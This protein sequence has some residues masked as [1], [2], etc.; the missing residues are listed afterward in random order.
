[1][2]AIY[3][4]IDGKQVGPYTQDQLRQAIN[5]GQVTR[6][7]PAWHEGLTEWIHV[8]GLINEQ[9]GSAWVPPPLS[10]APLLSKSSANSVTGQQM[11]ITDGLFLG[12]RIAPYVLGILFFFM[13]FAKVTEKGSGRLV[14]APSGIQLVT[15]THLSDPAN[16]IDREFPSDSSALLGLVCIIVALVLSFS[17]SKLGAI[18]SAIASMVALVT[19]A[20]SIQNLNGIFFPRHGIII[21]LSMNVEMDGGVGAALV[22]LSM[23][24]GTLYSSARA[25]KRK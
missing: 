9:P 8:G 21:P 18:G 10:Q 12:F 16:G 2:N 23:F 7:T 24:I 25:I 20:V 15:G 5:Q 3:L 1:M 6:E 22:C 19:V 11:S 14:F 4:S 13:P 17:P